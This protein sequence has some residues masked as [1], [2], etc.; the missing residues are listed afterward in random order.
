MHDKWKRKWVFHVNMLRKWHIPTSTGY[1]AKD[2]E[3]QESEDEV[4]T[5]DDGGSGE[6]RVGEQLDGAQ[7]EELE[8]LL[9]EFDGVLPLSFV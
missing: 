7:W 8:A 9:A 1:F 2:A 3:Q 4:P 6:L 5:W